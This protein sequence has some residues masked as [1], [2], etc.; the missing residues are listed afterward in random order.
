MHALDMRFVDVFMFRYFWRG[1]EPSEVF[2]GA[3]RREPKAYD[4]NAHNL[5]AVCEE[6]PK[7]KG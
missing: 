3:T 1:R 5:F 7:A 6:R 4:Q 2:G